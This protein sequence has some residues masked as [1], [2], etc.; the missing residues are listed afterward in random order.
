M[1]IAIV[2][3][4][5]I[6]CSL[7]ARLCRRHAVVLVARRGQAE[8]IERDGLTLRQNGTETRLRL[9]VSDELPANCELVLLTVK[10]Q[11]VQDACRTIAAAPGAAPVV[12][13]QNGI[14]ADALA[15]AELGQ[16]RILGA[17]VLGASSYVATGTVS[18]EFEGW[19]VL[20]EPFGPVRARTHQIAAVL[21]DARPTYVTD[22]LPATRWSKLITN[23]NNGLSAATGCLL[24][25]LLSSR[26]G[27]TLPVRTMKEGVQVARAAGVRLDHGLYGFTPSA[28]GRNRRAPAAMAAL[29]AALPW[30]VTAL[31]EAAAVRI[32]MAAAHTGLGRL[33]IRGS[34]WQSV[35]RRRPTEIDFLNGAVVAVGARVGVPTPYNR[36]IVERV[37]E[38][39]ERQ[40]FFPIEALVPDGRAWEQPVANR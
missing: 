4:G 23:L 24:V 11:D 21:Q 28:F 19:L 3:A 34:T 13:M 18:V 33:P 1:R 27:R 39:E 8:L 32:L 17:V 37:H 15:A 29:Q 7:A 40:S 12:A 5:A 9:P 10:T 26:L 25:E 38:V 36:L 14:Q 20:G 31:P 16:E 22:D 2:G 35:V 30:L 6:G